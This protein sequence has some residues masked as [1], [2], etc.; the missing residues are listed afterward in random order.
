MAR[1]DLLLQQLLEAESAAQVEGL[2]AA[3]FEAVLAAFPG[4]TT[5]PAQI[6]AD[7]AALN[8]YGN[9]IIRV[10]QL[11]KARGHPGP[12]RAL[13]GERD[14]NPVYRWQDAFTRSQALAAA[15]RHTESIEV[16][17]SLLAELDQMSG[18][19]LDDMRAK[20]FGALGT[21]WF[22][23]G[24]ISQAF[25]WTQRALQACVANDDTQ[26]IST[27]RQNLQVLDALH[28]PTVDPQAGARLLQ[29]RRLIASAQAASDDF[30]YA[31]SNQILDQALAIIEKGDE[32]L[33]SSFA[34][35]IYGLR[36]WNHF[37]LGDKRAARADTERALA[38]CR[39]AD[40]PDGVRIYT[41][42][43]ASLSRT[44]W[45]A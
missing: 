16:L 28:L 44:P 43:V 12:L 41:A 19:A 9:T 29:T 21:V 34:G 3:N 25:H 38:E 45:S 18:S 27:Y 40:D 22:Q 32:H 37:H 36:G 39:A 33:R 11:L 17:S 6:R 31:E 7:P 26:G 4:W 20:V 1:S 13:H 14:N 35:K 15:D 30:D 2:V 24:D 8:R 5:V 10:A 42:N 23:A